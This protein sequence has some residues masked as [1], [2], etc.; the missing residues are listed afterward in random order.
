MGNIEKHEKDRSRSSPRS[1]HQHTGARIVIARVEFG[2]TRGPTEQRL[3]AANSHSF[4]TL[5]STQIWCLAPF[6]SDK[7]ESPT[8]GSSQAGEHIL[9]GC[10]QASAS[11]LDMGVFK[12]ELACRAGIEHT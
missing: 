2:D 1:S 10:R 5:Q 6:F 8:G 12:C 4:H 7:I 9:N 3:V 11:G